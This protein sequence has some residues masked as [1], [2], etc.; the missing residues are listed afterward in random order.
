MT[1]I[2]IERYGVEDAI[3]GDAKRLREQVLRAPLGMCLRDVD[4]KHDGDEGVAHFGAIN[5]DG[6]LVGTVSIARTN[7]QAE[8]KQM[9]VVPEWVGQGVGR[10]LV[11]DAERQSLAEGVQSI[12]LHARLSAKAFYVALGYAAVSEPHDHL[13]IAHLWMERQLT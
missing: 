10:S 7:N 9:C 12:R 11:Q 8:L 6:V 1:V 2:L 13:G 3:Y 5:G 4:V